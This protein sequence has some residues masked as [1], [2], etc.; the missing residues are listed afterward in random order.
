MTIKHTK[1]ISTG[2]RKSL[3]FLLKTM[4]GSD[5]VHIS[6]DGI[7]L[8]KKYE[9]CRLTAYKPVA[10]EKYWTIG[11]GRC[12]SSITEGMRITQTKAEQWLKEDLVKFE[13][14]VDQYAGHLN[15]NINQYSALCSFTYNCG[16]GN[17]QKLVKNKNL[18]QIA[19]DILLYTKAGGKTLPG[20]VKRRKDEQALFLSPTNTDGNNAF[21]VN[22]ILK[23]GNNGLEVRKLQS[24]LTSIGYSLDIDGD[25]GNK[26][27]NIVIQFQKESGLVADGIVGTKT[28]KALDDIKIYS[29][30]NDGNK[31]ISPNF[32]IKEFA[33]SDGSDEIVL[34]TDFIV[35]KLQKIRSH[36]NKPITI[37]SGYRNSYHNK[38]VGGSSNS[39]HVKGRAFDIVVKGI[40]P[41]EVAKYAQSIGIKGIIRYSWG[42]HIDSRGTKYWA[43]DNNG[44]KT[45]V[46]GF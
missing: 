5:L 32:K 3:F 28:W 6:N 16:P 21:N 38:K 25:F 10:T 18:S 40:T 46:N 17:L 36:F 2:T 7:A 19:D 22:P 23:I 11:Y 31:S 15:L 42:V 26:T 27:K 30:L 20:L 4:K 33:C 24:K 1:L 14:Y 29:K 39:Y 35:D 8:I 13:K 37:N 12:N 43:V 41:N 44:K 9:G 34:H 45:P